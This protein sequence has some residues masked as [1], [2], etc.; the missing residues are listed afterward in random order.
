[1]N[2]AV[3]F[4]PDPLDHA[5]VDFKSEREPFQAAAVGMILNES[6]TGCALVLKTTEAVRP[7]LIIKVQVGKL[8]PLMARIVWVKVLDHNLIKAG[9][10]FLE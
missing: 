4:Q 9:I 7:D 5:L 6:Y 2:R 8:S 1:M 3:R 10:Q